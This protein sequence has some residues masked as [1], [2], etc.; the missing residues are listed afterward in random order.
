M[1]YSFITTVGSYFLGVKGELEI[2]LVREH[3][4]RHVLERLFLDQ[5]LEFLAALLKP[6]FVGGV[7][8]V[9]EAVGV[10]KVVL[11]VW[12]DRLLASDV[13]HV[14]L[15]ALLRLRKGMSIF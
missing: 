12:P 9:D 10:F 8:H 1:I 5:V 4:H 13:P 6:H 2:L 3:Q 14:E 11:P 7:H 15:E